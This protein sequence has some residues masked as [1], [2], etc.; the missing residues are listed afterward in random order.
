MG[1]NLGKVNLTS[2][3]IIAVFPYRVV[4]FCSPKYKLNSKSVW[5]LKFSVE[6]VPRQMFWRRW[7]IKRYE[8]ILAPMWKTAHPAHFLSMCTCVYLCPQ[9][10]YI[11][12]NSFWDGRC[13]VQLLLT[14]HIY[15]TM[16]KTCINHILPL[17]GLVFPSLK[18]P[19]RISNNR[20][21]LILWLR[22]I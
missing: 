19:I 10:M 7:W 5:L 17:S 21:S 6:S 14:P 2:E 9:Y 22:M 12:V 18:W 8:F 15:I 1:R 4:L 3:S 20:I 11:Q 13:W 16:I